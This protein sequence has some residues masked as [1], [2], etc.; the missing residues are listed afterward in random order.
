MKQTRLKFYE[1]AKCSTCRKAANF[2]DEHKID[3]EK[4]AIVDKP[5][6]VAELKKMLIFLQGDVRK[7]FNTSGELYRE[8]GLSKKIADMT[9]D[10]CIDLLSQHGKL[11]KRPFLINSHLGFVGFKENE[12]LSVCA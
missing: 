10:D 1:Y 8:M 4:I 7:L 5:P 6:S 11:I 3:Y 12:Y 9:D 2:L